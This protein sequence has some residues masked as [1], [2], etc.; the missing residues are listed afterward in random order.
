MQRSVAYQ[1]TY[2][3][4]KTGQI[5]VVGQAAHRSGAIPKSTATVS[6]SLVLLEL[7]EELQ[8]DDPVSNIGTT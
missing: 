7:F 4:T 6:I 8:K 1:Y 3:E 2:L 5:S